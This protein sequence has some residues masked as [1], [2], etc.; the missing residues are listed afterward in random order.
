[1]VVLFPL[2]WHSCAMKMAVK[3]DSTNRIVLTRAMREAAGIRAGEK[4]EV[5]IT[6]GVILISA[7]SVRAKLKK[8]G[9][10]TVIDAPVPDVEI[11]EAVDA[12]RH[13]DR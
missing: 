1:M 9:K 3:P 12:V 6:P 11:A 2:L 5:S 13:Y 4:L 10:L 7:P 8:K